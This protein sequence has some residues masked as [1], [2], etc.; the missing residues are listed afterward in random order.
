MA[1]TTVIITQ[2]GQAI[3]IN[4]GGAYGDQDSYVFSLNVERFLYKNHPD[5]FGL[6][7]TARNSDTQEVICIRRYH[8]SPNIQTLNMR[9]N[10]AYALLQSL[11]TAIENREGV[12]D[13]RQAAT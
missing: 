2:V 10:E 11:L 4:H 12:W 7:I 9:L 13:A 1:G 5:R 8:R 6:E 3:E